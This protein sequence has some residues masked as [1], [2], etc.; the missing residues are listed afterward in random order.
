MLIPRNK[1]R[2]LSREE[3]NAILERAKTEEPL[4]LEK[5]DLLA[6]MLAA[7]RV[8]LPFVLAMAGVLLLVYFLI[9]AW[10]G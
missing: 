5:G 8:F 6:I 7:V 3:Q 10:A 9:V 4:E 2:G 1:K